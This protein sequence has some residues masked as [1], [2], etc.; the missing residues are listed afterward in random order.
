MR[1]KL[2]WKLKH[3]NQILL[4]QMKATRGLLSDCTKE[5]KSYHLS[6]R[7]S[8]ITY[9]SMY[10]ERPVPVANRGPTCRLVQRPQK[11]LPESYFF[12][13]TH[14]HWANED[15][16][17]E[18]RPGAWESSVQC[19]LPRWTSNLQKNNSCLTLAV[20][21]LERTR[22]IAEALNTQSKPEYYTK[23]QKRNRKPSIPPIMSVS[24]I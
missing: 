21:I 6:I 7:K 4:V 20:T 24:D 15:F 23:T 18:Q 5:S 8:K 12:F 19:M 9:T 13:C 17:L 22:L 1:D 16:Q 10:M 14:C 2:Q 11:P 3:L